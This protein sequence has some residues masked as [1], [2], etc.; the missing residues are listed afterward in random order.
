MLI[1]SAGYAS[2]ASA[3]KLT[4]LRSCTAGSNRLAQKTT[5]SVAEPN[6]LLGLDAV[7]ATGEKIGNVFHVLADEQ[8]RLIAAAIDRGGFL[9]LGARKIAVAWS[10]LQFERG[11]REGVDVLELSRDQMRVAGDYM[12][13]EPTVLLGADP[14]HAPAYATIDR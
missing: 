4:D 9:G 3:Q 11:G 6:S 7:D 14:N 2:N 8:G 1:I 10:A 12:P 13:G 5:P